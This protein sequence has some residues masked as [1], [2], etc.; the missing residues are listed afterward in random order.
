LAAAERAAEPMVQVDEECVQLP[1]SM[2]EHRRP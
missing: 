2:L 1:P